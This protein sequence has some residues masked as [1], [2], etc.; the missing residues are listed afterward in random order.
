MLVADVLT[1][2]SHDLPIVNLARVTRL[3]YE[4]QSL[5][6]LIE[7]ESQKY[8]TGPD[9]AAAAMNLS[10]LLQLIGQQELALRYQGEA[11][12]SRRIFDVDSSAKPQL[13]VL[14]FVAP[15]DLKTNLPLEFLLEDD[16]VQI[17]QLYL[18]PGAQPP[19]DIPPH[20]LAIVGIGEG[21]HTNQILSD[22]A[23]WLKHWPRPVVNDPAA[24]L[25]TGREALYALL[26]DAPGL[27]VPYVLRLQRSEVEKITQTSV[28]PDG[29]IFPVTVRPVNSH[30][31]EGLEK[32]DHSS[33]LARYLETHPEL[34]FFVSHFIDYASQ[35]GH[36][37]KY[38]IALLNGHPYLCHLA[39]GDHWMVH[40]LNAGMMDSEVKR[41]EEGRALRDFQTDFA[42]KYR[43]ALTEVS[44][45]LGLDY[46]ILD[47][48]VLPDGRFLVFEASVAMIVH[49]LDSKVMFPDKPAAMQRLFQAFGGFLKQKATLHVP[50]L[51]TA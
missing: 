25:R 21:D 29:L 19:R 43:A 31:G 48:A 8:E 50:A 7:A 33:D 40:Y 32:I 13:R 42:I 6:P 38:R 44:D 26:H 22:M 10:I 30:A 28:L 17:T 36:Y 5:R 16:A 34:E 15:G 51:H 35:D 45:R 47:C 4:G 11:L 49:A 20:D 39:I 41:Q 2:Q 18:Q 12:A 3:A 37:R 23:Q 14:V 27:A 9:R 46:A 24:V 1:Q